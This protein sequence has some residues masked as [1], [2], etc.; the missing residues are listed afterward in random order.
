MR[1]AL[2]TFSER[3]AITLGEGFCALVGRSVDVGLPR[4]E[5]RVRFAMAKLL[6]CLGNGPRRGRPRAARMSRGECYPRGMT[7]SRNMFLPAHKK[8]APRANHDFVN[9]INILCCD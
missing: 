2:G 9:K 6:S 5:A 4:A 8:V 1:L 3:C 7:M